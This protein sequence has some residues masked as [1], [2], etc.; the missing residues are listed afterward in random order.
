[1]AGWVSIDHDCWTFWL[2]LVIWIPV[3]NCPCLGW[4]PWRT[5]ARNYVGASGVQVFKRSFST[6]ANFLGGGVARS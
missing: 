4:L 3:E 5:E 1:M 2:S 6:I